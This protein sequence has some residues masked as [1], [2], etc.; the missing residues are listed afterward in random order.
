MQNMQMPKYDM[1]EL[2]EMMTS[3]FKGS[4]PAA[5]GPSGR[6]QLKLTGKRK[7]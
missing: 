3:L 5:A 4:T 7:L 6:N 2:S 1:P